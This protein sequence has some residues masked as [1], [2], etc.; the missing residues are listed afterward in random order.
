MAQY[1]DVEYTLAT[2]ILRGATE[3]GCDHHD[4]VNRTENTTPHDIPVSKFNVERTIED[5]M[6]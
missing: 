1:D 6:K 4:A 3:H 5:A 2:C